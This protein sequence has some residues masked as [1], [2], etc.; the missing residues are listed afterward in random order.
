MARYETPDHDIADQDVT[1][2]VAFLKT[3]TGKYE[4]IPLKDVPADQ[5][6]QAPASN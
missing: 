3:L 4:G 1:D 6:L 2:I 5:P